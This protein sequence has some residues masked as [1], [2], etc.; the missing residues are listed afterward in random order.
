SFFRRMMSPLPPM[1]VML[2]AASG[3]SISRV[4]A[5]AV[6]RINDVG[7]APSAAGPTPAEAPAFE[8]FHELVNTLRALQLKHA[9]S[10][11]VETDEHNANEL[12]VQFTP[13]PA[14]T[15]ELE[16]VRR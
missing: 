8:D 9:L 11:G 14:A 1:A 12:V 2:F 15:A 6:D 13:T 16:L 10:I 4:M 5:L 3:W 7:N